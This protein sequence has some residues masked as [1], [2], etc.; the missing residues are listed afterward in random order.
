MAVTP[1]PL[2]YGQR[3]EAPLDAFNQWFRAR[4]EYYAKL[5]SWGQDPTNV[6]LND[7]QKQQMVRLAQSLGAVVDEGHN[8]Q[9]VDDSGNF[10]AKSHALRNTLIVAG[11]AAASLATMGAA[12]VFSA[13][14]GGASAAGA[15]GAAAGASTAG[16]GAAAA[17]AGAA[18]GGAG[19]ATAAGASAVPWGTI[20]GAGTQLFGNLFAAHEQAAGADQA[21]QIAAASAKY[22][23]DLIAKANADSLAFQGKSAEN[24]YQNNEA[25]RQ[26]NYGIFAARERRLGTIGDEVGLGAREIPAYV[27]G[28]D[29]GFGTIGD[30]ATGT[31]PAPSS[32][33]PGNPADPNAIM[34][35]VTDNYKKLGVAPTGPGSGPTDIAYMAGKVKET[36]G[37]TPGNINY[38]FGPQGRIAAEIQ[39]TRSGSRPPAAAG[40]APAPMAAATPFMNTYTPAAVPQAI[41]AYT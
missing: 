36:G 4:P 16:A 13:G 33:A 7:D 31:P 41:G 5:A 40:P 11:I 37:L 27:P 12:G 8:G 34:A 26:G 15:G 3:G 9:E 18:A 30:A 35:A 2:G 10:Q 22:Q 6:H 38:W 39:Q 21:A 28:V 17:G 29:P 1:P 24:A 20:I 23:A 32:G 25:A 14:A 19:V